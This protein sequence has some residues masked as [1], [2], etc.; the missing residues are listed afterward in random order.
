MNNKIKKCPI[1]FYEKLYDNCCQIHQKYFEEKILR[2]KKE[3]QKN[4]SKSESKN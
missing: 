2:L 1:K 3:K 4:E